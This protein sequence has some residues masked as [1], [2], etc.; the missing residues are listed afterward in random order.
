[1]KP[2]I[3]L[4]TTIPSYLTAR[5]SRDLIIAAHQEVTR[6]WW[7]TQA[8]LYDLFISQ[9]VVEEASGGDPRA[10]D[11]RLSALQGI[12]LLQ[13]TAEAVRLAD[14]I[15]HETPMPGK[16]AVDALHVALA[17]VHGM[18]YLL[19]WN[20]AHIANAR[21]RHVIESICADAGG[22]CPVICTPLELSEVLG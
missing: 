22:V 14:R 13:V 21:L 19:T 8:A 7:R 5:P 1:M 18:D 10:A 6:E 17:T 15:V 20:C 2:S 11:E 12:P 3:Y 9:A 4:E 16:A